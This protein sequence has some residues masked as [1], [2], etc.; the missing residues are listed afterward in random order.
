MIARIVIAVVVG[1]VVTLA[2]ILLGLI[3]VALHIDIAET[4][5]HFL[6]SY[7]AVI[8]ILAGLIQFFTGRFHLPG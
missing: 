6:Q 2:C 7:A 8:G 3:L 4:V 1:V 5:G